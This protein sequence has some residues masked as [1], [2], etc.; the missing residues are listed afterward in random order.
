MTS[1][2]LPADALT[3]LVDGTIR[4]GLA[5]ALLWI[6][7]GLVSNGSE[8]GEDVVD[9]DV[10]LRELVASPVT[11][12]EPPRAKGVVAR[13]AAVAWGVVSA[14]ILVYAAW[15]AVVLALT[16]AVPADVL[17]EAIPPTVEGV[18]LVAATGV[19]ALW[20]WER[21]VWEARTRLLSPAERHTLRGGSA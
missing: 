2:L 9:D 17:V 14:A 19:V 7:A 6:V 21:A 18:A 4:L 12:D 5:G 13:V 15:G 1:A 20:R 10:V 8:P 3:G 11:P 16:V